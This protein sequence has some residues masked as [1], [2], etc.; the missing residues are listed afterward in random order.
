MKVRTVEIRPVTKREIANR[1]IGYAIVGVS[2]SAE[3]MLNGSP[4]KGD[5]VA[6]NTKNH[7]NQWLVSAKCVKENF[8]P[9]GK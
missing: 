5:M 7:N 6:K 8:I 1:L 4:L 9:E 2:V 3:N